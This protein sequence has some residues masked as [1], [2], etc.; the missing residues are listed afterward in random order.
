MVYIVGDIHGE[1]S[2]LQQL[3]KYII[4]ADEAPTFVFIGDYLDK[5]EN[6]RQTLEF[7][8]EL[9]KIHE[10][11]FLIGNHEYIWMEMKEDDLEAVVYLEKFGGIQTLKSFG[12]IDFLEART[13]MMA[14]FKSFFEGLLP[15]FRYKNYLITHSGV[16]SE[17]YSGDAADIPVKEFLFN[18]Y[19]FINH[20]ALFGN[21]D[22]V[23]FGHTAF[24]SPFYD[25][26]KI[27]IDTGA[28]FLKEQP[29]TA[30]NMDEEYFI[31]SDDRRFSLDETTVSI[32]PNIIRSKPWR[33]FYE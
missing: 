9:A 25:G 18:R 27:G 19:E 21:Q 2:K 30:F 3:V 8:V 16:P 11:Q 31:N 29:L 33:T 5:G 22:K 1:V 4:A 14:V 15:F 10:C 24:F 28:C 26:Y 23:I 17:Y 7:L 6:P 32:C 12:C 13:Q 20:K